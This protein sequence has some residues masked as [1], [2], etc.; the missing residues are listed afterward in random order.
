MLPR[1]AVNGLAKNY[2]GG[3]ANNDVSLT[4]MPGEIHGVLGDNGAG[5][6][7]LAHCLGGLVLPDAGTIEID[8]KP[9]CIATPAEARAAG[10]GLVRQDFSLFESLTVAETIALGLGAAD[11]RRGLPQRI[12]EVSARHA[13]PLDPDRPVHTLSV[14]ER[15]Q[16]EI[17]RCLLN[18]CRVLILD[19]PT[20]GLTPQGAAALFETLRRLSAEKR[21]V[22]VLSRKPEELPGL[23]DRATVLRGGRVV[24][25]VTVADTSAADLARLMIGRDRPALG[26][27]RPGIAG[28]EVLAVHALSLPPD[29]PHGTALKMVSLSARAGEILGIAGV[30]G[31]G[32]K[33]L[34]TALSGERLAPQAEAVVL[35]GQAVGRLGAA[36][37]RRLGLGFVPGKRLGRGAVPEMTLAENG[38]LTGHLSRPLEKNGILSTRRIGLF[39]E[40]IIAAH[41]VATRSRQTPA[42]ALSAG[43]VQKFILGRELLCKT[44]VLLVAYP[45]LG[46]DAEAASAIHKTLVAARDAGVAVVVLSDDLDE[47][48]SLCDRLVV[49]HEGRLSAPIPVQ[50]ASP[51]A[52]GQMMSGAQP[53]PRETVDAA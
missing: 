17:V 51:E 23:C 4:V 19:E 53:I 52:L 47:L 31:N 42:R 20:S 46:A 30:P 11:A 7:T 18:E 25:T 40:A 38:F 39:A 29:A 2:P 12:R 28:D 41:R 6:S 35:G 22:V 3:H 16:V 1:L 32:Q 43:E 14:G 5:K 26:A 50:G 15:R 36:A 9:V 27:D 49:L 48:L 34:V 8:G 10:I 24:A 44:R 33:E 45:T 37:R 21:G 13:M